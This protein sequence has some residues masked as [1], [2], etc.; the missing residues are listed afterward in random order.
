[1]TN[2]ETYLRVAGF[3][4]FGLLVAS[5]STPHALDWKQ[6]LAPLHPFLR[7][8]FWVYGVFIV[9][10]IIAFGTI[11]LGNSNEMAAGTLLARWL[12]GFIGVFWLARLFVQLFIFDARPFL[13]NW[14]Y[15]IGYHSLTFVFLYFT[16]VY[17]F[18]ALHKGAP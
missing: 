5:A 4:H 13:T 18:A 14:F 9:L 16:A 12:C 11:T 17:G 10:V 15:R 6:N 8:L 1:M 7:K 3:L 2:L